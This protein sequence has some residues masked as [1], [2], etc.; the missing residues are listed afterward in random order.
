MFFGSLENLPTFYFVETFCH[1]EIV[2]C[3]VFHK[4]SKIGSA[5]F[6]PFIFQKLFLLIIFSTSIRFSDLYFN[7]G[8]LKG[9]VS[10]YH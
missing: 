1:F 7:Q 5:I 9:E 10:L 2:I 8:I 4:N 3:P 6:V